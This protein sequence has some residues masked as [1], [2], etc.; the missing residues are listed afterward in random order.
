[1]VIHYSKSSGEYVEIVFSKNKR[2]KD[3][4]ARLQGRHGSTSP[5]Y[6]FDADALI[7][8]AYAQGVIFTGLDDFD[9]D[10]CDLALKND[11]EYY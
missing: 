8:K 1:M 7:F 4:T 10:N 11:D 6:L 9:A 2:K 3:G 5:Y